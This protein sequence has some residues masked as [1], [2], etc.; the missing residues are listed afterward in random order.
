[1]D[2]WEEVEENSREEIKDDANWAEVLDMVSAML[3]KTEAAQLVYELKIAVKNK[4]QQILN[5]LK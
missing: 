5:E 4:A 3:N 1:M 2:N